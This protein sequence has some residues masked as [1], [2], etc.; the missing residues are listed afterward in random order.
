MLKHILVFTI[1]G[2]C[3]NLG[4]S[5]SGF[6]DWRKRPPSQRA[7]NRQVLEQQ[8]RTEYEKKRCREG[9]P[10]LAFSLQN[11]GVL[12]CVNT[13]A[14]CMKRMGIQAKGKRKFKATTNS[15]HDFPVAPNLLKRN[16]TSSNP[17]EVWVTDITYLWTSEGWLYLA[18]ILDLYSRRVVGWSMNERMTSTLVCDALRMAWFRRRCPKGVIV[19]SDRGSQYCGKDFQRLLKKYGML[20]SMSRKGDCWDNAVA[21]S[22]F[23]SLKV[24]SIHGEVFGTR[25]A[26]RKE[27]F[28]YIEVYYNRAR[29]HSTLGYKT[30]EQFEQRK[31][32]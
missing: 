28:E 21:E 14:T 1:V 30:P 9:S 12:V 18:V 24:E 31:A 6:D 4:V 27:V 32:A 29:L 20:S 2:M 17:N 22:F 8:I 10:R 16:F 19:H 13:V 3:R 25:E 7:R 15:A 11:Q 26:M 5:R 23:H